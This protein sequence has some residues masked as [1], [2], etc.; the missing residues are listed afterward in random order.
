M[1]RRRLAIMVGILAV[2]LF[3]LIA[4]NTYLIEP[5][6][7]PTV[8][9]QALAPV[10]PSTET[11]RAVGTPSPNVITLEQIRSVIP[12]K[13]KEEIKMVFEEIRNPFMWQD[14]IQNYRSSQR[15]AGSPNT[16]YIPEQELKP[17]TIRMIMIRENRKVAMLEDRFL[18][19]G[20]RY[21]GNKV[22]RIGEGEVVLTR[23]SKSVR[24]QI[25]PMTYGY[26]PAKAAKAEEE[27]P[28]EAAQ[29]AM[30]E[31]IKKK[32]EQL[33]KLEE[34]LAPFLSQ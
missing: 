5:A 1:S 4:A 24:I 9:R 2:L 26:V 20:D 12:R 30:P 3:L 6:L 27:Q 15:R 13:K 11:T 23:K 22:S 25:D 17:P 28:E 21:R 34:A 31:S 16:V 8:P 33:K 18:I 29:P 10:L 32:L 7:A 19:E 14:E